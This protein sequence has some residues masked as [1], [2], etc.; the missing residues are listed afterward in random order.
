VLAGNL[1][2]VLAPGL[3]IVLCVQIGPFTHALVLIILRAC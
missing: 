3:G 1:A 2:L